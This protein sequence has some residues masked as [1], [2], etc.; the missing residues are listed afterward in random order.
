MNLAEARA[1]VQRRI[2]K[3]EHELKVLRKTLR[4]LD[5]LEKTPPKDVKITVKLKNG[6]EKK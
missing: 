4:W 1:R 3:L 6:D 5:E 2:E